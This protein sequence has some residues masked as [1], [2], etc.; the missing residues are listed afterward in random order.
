[1]HFAFAPLCRKQP[2]DNFQCGEA[3][4]ERW[5]KEKALQQQK[6]G[7]SR[8]FALLDDEHP[9]V[10]V[11]FY[12]LSADSLSPSV[13]PDQFSHQ[14]PSQYPIPAIRLVRLARHNEYKGKRIGGLLLID[15]LKRSVD[16]SKK[17]GVAVIVVDAKTVTAKNFYQRY[18]FRI[19]P[20]NSMMLWMRI[21][22]A[23]LTLAPITET[24]AL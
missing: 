21:K 14:Y 19:F 7:L 20:D 4:L 1:M 11:G 24:P 15:A 5:I 2:R 23:E 22:D 12:S 13:F 8:T 10:M 16:S 9:E 18:G 17:I 3:E 6:K